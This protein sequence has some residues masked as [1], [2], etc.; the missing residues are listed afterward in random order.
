MDPVMSI[1]DARN[2]FLTQLCADGDNN[3]GTIAGIMR[4]TRHTRPARPDGSGGGFCYTAEDDYTTTVALLTHYQSRGIRFNLGDNINA[5]EAL[6]PTYKRFRNTIMCKAFPEFLS[7]LNR[8]KDKAESTPKDLNVDAIVSR[9]MALEQQL[10]RLD[11]VQTMLQDIQT[12][13]D[14]L[15]AKRAEARQLAQQLKL[16]K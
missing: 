3:P 11:T 7:N 1:R 4:S 12:M 9:R 6:V 14:V 2:A 8:G 13:D 10:E 15:N 16:V 5:A